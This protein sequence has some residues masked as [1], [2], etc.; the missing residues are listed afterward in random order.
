VETG[1]GAFYQWS[2]LKPPE[3]PRKALEIELNSPFL[4]KVR[5]S[6]SR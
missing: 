3:A 5:E 4:K 6:S 1:V 2:R